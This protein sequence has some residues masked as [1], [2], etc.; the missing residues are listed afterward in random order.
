M[1]KEYKISNLQLKALY[2]HLK[3][4]KDVSDEKKKSFLT[5]LES[6][7]LDLDK[8]RIEIVEK[9]ARKDSEGDPIIIINLEGKRVYDV[10]DEEM[11]KIQDEVKILVDETYNL[12]LQ[13]GEEDLEET[14][15]LLLEE[16]KN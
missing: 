15:N 16:V 12:V 4:M 1:A 11:S 5:R 3:L 9:Y 2:D 13:E 10:A 8:R 14:I 6:Y 7:F